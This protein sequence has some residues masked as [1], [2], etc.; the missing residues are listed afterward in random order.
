MPS[1]RSTSFSGDTE[2][3]DQSDS[4]HDSSKGPIG[5]NLLYSGQGPLVDLVFVHGLGG[6]SRR[7]W[8]SLDR[9]AN[10]W[11]KE[12]L[13]RDP[14]FDQARAH[15]FGYEADWRKKG[16]V[17]D[18][19][20]FARSLISSLQNSPEIR[21]SKVLNSQPMS[22]A[23]SNHHIDQDCVNRPQHGWHCD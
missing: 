4:D 2:V 1:S 16:S 3:S 12:W 19:H 21:K 23:F 7:T 11:P 15:S 14:D 17:L 8:T 5:L 10:F 6:G 13:S 22:I 20:D 9:P 18:I